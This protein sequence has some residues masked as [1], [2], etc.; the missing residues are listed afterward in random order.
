MQAE[1]ILKEL[2][3][4]K[5]NKENFD[6]ADFVEKYHDIIIKFNKD[7][8]KNEYN[9]MFALKRTND[10]FFKT[11]ITF[12]DHRIFGKNFDRARFFPLYDGDD[13][14][15]SK[16]ERKFIKEFNLNVIC[17]DLKAIQ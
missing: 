16:I 4:E 13:E 3:I 2:N 7:E 8:N 12:K 17:K 9:F 5:I 1:D 10:K 6:I 14:Y 11:M 15:Y